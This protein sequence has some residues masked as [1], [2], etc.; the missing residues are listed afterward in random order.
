MPSRLSIRALMAEFVRDPAIE[1]PVV[2]KSA[3]LAAGQLPR[4]QAIPKSN[5]L[6]GMPAE[7]L[8]LIARFLP[9]SS[10]VAL[11]LT[12]RMSLLKLGNRSWKEINT[13][14]F[15]HAVHNKRYCCTPERETLI[16]LLNRDL[17]DL[18]YC[19]F[20]N[21]LHSPS[22]TLSDIR[23]PVSQQR[24]CT[25]VE[26]MR[27]KDFKERYLHMHDDLPFSEI[28]AFMKRHL[29]FGID[30]SSQLRQMSKT[31]TLRIKK[32]TY[33]ITTLARVISGHLIIRSQYWITTPWYKAKGAPGAPCTAETTKLKIC[34]HSFP[35][36]LHNYWLGHGAGLTEKS[37]NG[38]IPCGECNSLQQCM[39]CTTEFQMETAKI[40]KRG[41]VIAIT[42]WQDLRDCSSPYNTKWEEPRFV[43]YRRQNFLPG[44]IKAAFEEF[45]P[46][47]EKP[48]PLKALAEVYESKFQKLRGRCR[49]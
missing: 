28:Q 9:A 8:Q 10:E 6:L 44:S 18:I 40:G 19:Y 43:T 41:S 15:P 49:I 34:P 14:S 27:R 48:V 38:N 29:R 42:V 3:R 23:N 12:C 11:T 25:K 13:P 47:L 21:I 17:K 39:Y 22:K 45:S 5:Q 35:N 31:S 1:L 33:Q 46:E 7:I 20:C 4:P 2:S 36:S 32:S 30:C 24:E 16:Q 26:A 37:K